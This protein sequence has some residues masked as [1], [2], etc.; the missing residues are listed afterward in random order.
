MNFLPHNPLSEREDNWVLVGFVLLGIV[1]LILSMFISPWLLLCGV[2][3][4]GASWA[5]YKEPM[6][7]VL[8]LAV[9]WPLEPFIVTWLSDDVFVYA[10][11]FSEALIYVLLAVVIAGLFSGR[12]KKRTTSIDLPMLLLLIMIAVSAI[13]NAVPITE[14]ILG[15]SL[16]LRF[17]LLFYVVLIRYP[18]KFWIKRLVIVI[19]IMASLQSLLGASQV[20]FG[21]NLNSFLLPSDGRT[22]SELQ[23]MEASYWDPGLRVFGTMGHFDRLGAFLTLAILL[24][25]GFIYEGHRKLEWQKLGIFSLIA[26]PTLILTFSHSAWFG[27]IL[28]GLAIAMVRKDKRVL[29]GAGVIVSLAVIVLAF[30]SPSMDLMNLSSQTLRDVAPHSITSAFFGV[31]PGQSSIDNS[32]L[33]LFSEIGIIGLVFYIW[34]YSMLVAVACKVARSS[35]IAITRA[36]SAGYVGISIA[37]ALNAVLM[38]SLEL[39]TLAPYLWILAG[40]VIVLGDREK[41][42]STR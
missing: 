14:A 28:G 10:R 11:F 31:G 33:T 17:M 35:K 40:C 38:T 29:V 4:L 32:W 19:L 26:I 12:Y 20:I 16:I 36:V 25:L 3:F 42:I 24:S 8:F 23:T 27:L 9:W 7:T 13:L 22:F 15:T 5:S 1:S 30:T 37:I 2:L 6:W 21:E 39:R 34:I 18:R 41:L